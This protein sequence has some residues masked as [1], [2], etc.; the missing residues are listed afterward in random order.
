MDVH[1]YV[2]QIREAS[3]Y[4]NNLTNGFQTDTALILGSGLGDFVTALDNRLEIPY[5]DI[6]HFPLST[7]AGH[8]G[9]LVFGSV[10]GKQVLVMKG[11]I[12]Y[13]EGYSMQQVSFPVRI[14]QWLGIK[15][16][17]VTNASG[18][19]NPT[20]NVG[21]LVIIND[22]I[23]MMGTNPLI[24]ANV[25]EFGVRFPDMSHAYNHDFINKLKAISNEHRL[26]LKTGVY[27]AV[28]G[29][30]YESPAEASMLYKLGA[31]MVGMSTVPEV[32]VAVHAGM[33][34]AGLSCITD[35]PGKSAEG[36]THE[37]VVKA[38]EK[39]G[40]VLQEVLIEFLKEV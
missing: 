35:M 37:E 19:L 27:A 28:T 3:E 1:Q 23:N 4:I 7:V 40:L 39:A 2:L 33:K 16:L 34:V 9:K 25:S 15:H 22:Q 12:H 17:I 21:D 13:Y 31:D 29:P 8:S 20:Y 18:G 14:M 36:V 30:Y 32:I 6:P 38:A 10:E 24:G 26:N 11:R 5:G